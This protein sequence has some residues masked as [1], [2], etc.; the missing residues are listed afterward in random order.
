MAYLGPPLNF[1]II[2]HRD[3]T[4]LSCRVKRIEASGNVYRL[5]LEPMELL[6]N[7]HSFVNLP[8][9]V[10]AKWHQSKLLLWGLTY[11]WL[12]Q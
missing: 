10:T 11:K 9:C 8:C 2:L 12:L 5:F 4:A 1:P 6:F 3:G 7:Y